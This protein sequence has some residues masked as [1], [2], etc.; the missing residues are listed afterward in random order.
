MDSPNVTCPD[1]MEH[2]RKLEEAA[3]REE[4]V[5]AAQ[6]ARFSEC[7]PRTIYDWVN[8]GRVQAIRLNQRKLRVHKPSLLAYL[9][10]V[11]DSLA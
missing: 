2:Y 9:K 10:A 1:L 6:A 4:F 11:N 3:R 8:A 5:S 7:T